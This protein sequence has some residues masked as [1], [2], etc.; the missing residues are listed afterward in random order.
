MQP[1]RATTSRH[2]R[3]SGCK[4][5]VSGRPLPPCI[6]CERRTE[7]PDPRQP[8]R[9]FVCDRIGG[10]WVCSGRIPAMEAAGA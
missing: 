10:V 7:P 8:L 4:S 3:C 6:S 9:E 2:A 1:D 5:A